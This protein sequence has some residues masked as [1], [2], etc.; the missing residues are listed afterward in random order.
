MLRVHG[1]LPT[2][3]ISVFD[4]RI[5]ISCYNPDSGTV[6]SLLDTDAPAAR[7]WAESTYESYRQEARPLKLETAVQ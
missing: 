3:G 4:D 7:K 6:Q 1:D 5:A 2:S